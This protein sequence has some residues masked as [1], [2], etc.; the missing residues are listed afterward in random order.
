MMLP[1]PRLCRLEADRKCSDCVQFGMVD[2]HLVFTN[3]SLVF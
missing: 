1:G 3:T 2:I